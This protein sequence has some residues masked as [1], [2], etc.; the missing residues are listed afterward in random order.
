MTRPDFR[1]AA[2][3]LLVTASVP[4]RAAEGGGDLASVRARGA[5]RHLGVR[6]ARFVTGGGDGL[7]VEIMKRFA[8]RLGVRYEYVETEWSEALG[9]LTGRDV[10]PRQTDLTAAAR[11]PV[12]GDVLASGITILPWRERVVAFSRPTFPTQ[13]WLVAPA[14]SPLVPIKPTGSVAEDVAATK[15]LLAARSVLG[16]S[17]T[18]LDPSLYQL[19]ATGARVRLLQTTHLDEVAP[20]L[21]RGEADLSLL[22]VADVILAME[23][24]P[25]A[26]KV[27]GPVSPPQEM[28]AVFRK[29]APELRREFDAYLEEIW[30]DGTY[31]TLVQAYVP[32]AVTVFPSFFGAGSGGR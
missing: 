3:A 13:V 26:L 18:C 8:A 20:A 14:A 25:G 4:A 16:V 32:G 21:I 2:L 11:R 9:D 30:R 31:R 28:G 19:S 5:L 24:W 23:S 27:I 29:D 10:G 22:D 1:W 17:G 6:Y 12:R 15:R 7:D